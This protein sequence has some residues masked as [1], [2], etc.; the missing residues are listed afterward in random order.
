MTKQRHTVIAMLTTV[1]WSVAAALNF[2]LDWRYHIINGVL[3]TIC[4]IVYA[5]QTITL[6]YA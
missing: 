4:A 2:S 1:I 6:I 3:N 5:L